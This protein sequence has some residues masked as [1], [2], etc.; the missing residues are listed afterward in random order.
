MLA[1]LRA[2]PLP[3]SAPVTIAVA[4][5]YFCHLIM[6]QRSQNTPDK[7]IGKFVSPA[8]ARHCA[9][10]ISEHLDIIYAFLALCKLLHRNMKYY[11]SN[12]V[13][14]IIRIDYILQR[15]KTSQGGSASV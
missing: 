11:F 3:Y 6:R 7:Q 13:V 8:S 5:D 12:V 14:T 1:V 15:P 2:F 9:Y 10:C 4:R